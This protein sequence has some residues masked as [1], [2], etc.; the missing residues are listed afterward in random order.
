MRPATVRRMRPLPARPRC[1]NSTPSRVSRQGGSSRP[2]L[3][4]SSRR[5]SRRTP[6][7]PTSCGR[8]RRR[9]RATPNGVRRSNRPGSSRRAATL[10]Q[11]RE[12]A[13]RGRFYEVEH[14]LEAVGSAVVR[15][16]NILR[17]R[18]RSELEEQPQPPV[19]VRR[20][21][22]AQHAQVLTIH[23]Q[24]QIEAL[25]VA[26]FHNARAQRREVISTAGGSLPGAR[27]GWFAHVIRGRAGRIHFD[28]K[29]R[30]LARSERAQHA[31]G[32][33]RAADVAETN[34]QDFHT[35][36][37]VCNLM[38]A[39]LILSRRVWACPPVSRAKVY[40]GYTPGAADVV[41]SANTRTQACAPR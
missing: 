10:A 31:L 4:I 14:L 26:G 11:V 7:N 28:G 15:V 9:R 25:E 12:Q 6:A 29:F 22:P 18:F 32:G 16:R 35:S 21:A 1:G 23:R 41:G 40:P 13:S 38:I 24:N 3:R 27:I 37:Y 5:R 20:R 8:P 34:K 19:R 30:R 2:R 33:R 39:R 17:T 36:A